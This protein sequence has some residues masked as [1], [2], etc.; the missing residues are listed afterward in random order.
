MSIA[1]H[2]FFDRLETHIGVLL[3][4]AGEE[5]LKY[6]CFQDRWKGELSRDWIYSPSEMASYVKQM[7]EYFAGER[8]IFNLPLQPSGTPFQ[9]KVWRTLV[10]IPYGTTITYSELAEKV[11]NPG[12]SRAVGNANGKNPLVIIQP[13]HR[14]IAANTKLGGFSAGTYRKKLLLGLEKGINTLF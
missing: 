10:D 2:I 3:M 5:G 13:C 4:A 14:V 6:V 11:G 8:Q 1:S 12:A 9:L 7:K